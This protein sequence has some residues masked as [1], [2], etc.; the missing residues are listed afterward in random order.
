MKNTKEWL[1]IPRAEAAL[2][3]A[4]AKEP[5]L[6]IVEPENVI[7]P[8]IEGQLKLY[9][10]TQK[11]RKIK[12]IRREERPPLVKADSKSIPPDPVFTEISEA[13]AR[14]IAKSKVGPKPKPPTRY[15]TLTRENARALTGLSWLT[16][17]E[18]GDHARLV[19]AY[20]NSGSYGAIQKA[21]VDP[22]K[23]WDEITNGKQ[24]S[25]HRFMFD[26]AERSKK[27]REVTGNFEVPDGVLGLGELA[28]KYGPQSLSDHIP[29][30]MESLVAGSSVGAFANLG[31]IPQ[32]QRDAIGLSGAGSAEETRDDPEFDVMDFQETR[33]DLEIVDADYQE[34]Y[35]SYEVNKGKYEQELE[36]ESKKI[37]QQR[38]S[39]LPP[40][41]G[42][43]SGV[44]E[45]C[46]EGSG[47][48]HIL[49]LHSKFT[50]CEIDGIDSASDQPFCVVNVE[51]G[52][53]FEV[54][55]E[56]IIGEPPS[57]CDFV[58]S[59]AELRKYLEGENQLSTT[60]DS[61][62]AIHERSTDE[63]QLRDESGVGNS[64]QQDDLINLTHQEIT[65]LTKDYVAT[66]SS[67]L[68]AE[69]VSSA[70]RR[71]EIISTE[72]IKK[73]P[74]RSLQSETIRRNHL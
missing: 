60:D 42:A 36:E 26:E 64:P 46:L 59:G 7:L 6:G 24:G 10:K 52:R 73:W 57:G 40:I 4:L 74:L 71:A 31:D 69:N 45:I 48:L 18:H 3:Q 20:L 43:F 11:F 5:M 54:T 25:F 8:V 35:E 66:R 62:D 38:N 58:F 17:K 13:D 56:L 44:F 21:A 23:Q 47:L 32:H 50:D 53:L 19:E 67:R 2:S 61:L 29:P 33:D 16:I 70:R 65:E 37:L 55:D 30:T 12:L 39:P 22:L 72:L 41:Q 1:Q 27:L 63:E 49:A 68:L 51:D 34:R 28:K 9:L 15:V 14:E